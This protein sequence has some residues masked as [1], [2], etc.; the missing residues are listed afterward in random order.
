MHFCCGEMVHLWINDIHPILLLS[1][2]PYTQ[3]T[4]LPGK[5][6]I[7]HIIS[8]QMGGCPLL[9]CFQWLVYPPIPAPVKHIWS[10][11]YPLPGI[12]CFKAP[13]MLCYNVFDTPPCIQQTWI[14]GKT[15]FDP[16]FTI[17][18]G[19]YQLNLKLSFAPS[20]SYPMP[21][22][23]RPRPRLIPRLGPRPRP[24]PR[25]R[26]RPRAFAIC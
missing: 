24:R 8:D 15:R 18:M 20:F 2:A 5:N 7:R 17:R 16:L 26:L 12:G 14:P 6:Q 13:E 19:S 9:C 3:T 11:I 10:W 1:H 21:M 22:P 4:C 25:A 23:P